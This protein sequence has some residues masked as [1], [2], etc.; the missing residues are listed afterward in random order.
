MRKKRLSI[1]EAAQRGIKCIR[2]PE[3][4]E[5]AYLEL[6]L[7]NGGAAPTAQLHDPYGHKALGVDDPQPM[8]IIMHDWNEK[9][10]E[11]Q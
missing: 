8:V 5:A 10:W 1:S 4:N 6:H 2:R 9:G 3:W 7:V 11:V